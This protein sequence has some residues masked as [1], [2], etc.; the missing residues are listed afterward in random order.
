MK[1]AVLMGG[2]S[3]ERAVSLASGC[4][5][6]EALRR[7]GHE[8]VAVDTARGALSR[9]DEA[10]I[11]EDGIR[12]LPGGVADDESLTTTAATSEILR[13]PEVSDAEIFFLTFHGGD[14]EDGTIQ[15]LLELARLPYVGSGPTGC[16]LAMD[17]DL[18]KRLFRDAGIRTPAWLTGERP[19]HDVVEALGWPVVV[20]PVTGGSSLRLSIAHDEDELARAVE[21]VKKGPG[22]LMYEGHVRGRELTVAVIGEHTLPVGEIIPEHEYFDYECKYQKGMAQ[23][24]FPADIDEALARRLRDLAA[25]IHRLLRLRDFSRV[26]FI[27]DERGEPWVLEANALPGMSGA[28]LVP[29]AGRAAGMSFPQLCDRIAREALER[30]S[31]E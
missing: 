21:D 6:T 14:G 29:K 9:A 20:K 19:A 7:A 11:L 16:M 18:S 31:K 17:K 4:E 25:E 13:D 8:V 23:E 26:D 28:S 15:S 5:V 10:R 2:A 24:I 22:E 27:V 30:L 1:I 12:S 3:E